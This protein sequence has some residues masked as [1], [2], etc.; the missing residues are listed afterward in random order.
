MVET[1][2]KLSDLLQRL[3]QRFVQC[4]KSFV[5]NMGFIDEFGRTDIT[6][7]SGE[8]VP[9]SQKRRA[10]VREA[11]FKFVGRGL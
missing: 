3:P 10:S 2:G 9:V 8:R 4:H 11:F 1:Y 5:V 6:L 7:T